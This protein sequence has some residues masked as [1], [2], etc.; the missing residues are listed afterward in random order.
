MPE[1]DSNPGQN[2]ENQQDWKFF[3]HYR[4]N[5]GHNYSVFYDLLKQKGEPI[6]IDHPDLFPQRNQVLGNIYNSDLQVFIPEQDHQRI[7]AIRDLLRMSPQWAIIEVTS[8]YGYYK[9]IKQFLSKKRS[10]EELIEEKNL[11][12]LPLLFEPPQFS[13][14]LKEKILAKAF[15]KYQPSSEL[16]NI[17]N[18]RTAQSL[19]KSEPISDQEEL[20]LLNQAYEELKNKLGE[21]IFLNSQ[22]IESR[23]HYLPRYLLDYHREIYIKTLQGLRHMGYDLKAFNVYN[24][25]TAESEILILGNPSDIELYKQTFAS[26]ELEF[27][28]SIQNLGKRDKIIAHHYPNLKDLF[29]SDPNNQDIVSSWQRAHFTEDERKKLLAKI[30]LDEQIANLINISDRDFNKDGYYKEIYQDY[31]N[32]IQALS[33]ERSSLGTNPITEE[34]ITSIVNRV[35]EKIIADDPDK[36]PQTL[37]PEERSINLFTASKTPTL[38]VRI[39]NGL[40]EAAT[41]S[42]ITAG[43]TFLVDYLRYSHDFEDALKKGIIAGGGIGAVTFLNSLRTQHRPK[44][45]N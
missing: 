17:V 20:D 43:I 29:R 44:R 4:N 1:R 30:L 22:N 11:P 18:Y 15:R 28:L 40:V 3:D 33:Q 8:S 5:W 14:T 19:L 36:F 45:Y 25:L 24:D 9:D 32:Q 7:R 41:S 26:P 13:K 10:Q 12:N 21:E 23:I 35:S 16:G 34:E 27:F 31:I 6:V 38:K 39:K 2:P 37:A 42:S